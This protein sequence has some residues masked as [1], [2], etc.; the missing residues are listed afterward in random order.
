MV[1]K[2]RWCDDI[3]GSRV[4]LSHDHQDST[5]PG[6]MSPYRELTHS[7]SISPH[8]PPPPTPLSLSFLMYNMCLICS[9]HIK[10]RC[11]CW[12]GWGIAVDHQDSTGPG[13]VPVSPDREQIHSFSL[14]SSLSISFLMYN[15]CLVCGVHIKMRWWCWRVWGTAV[16]WPPRRHR[17]WTCP[18]V[19]L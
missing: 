2:S 17:Y 10:M 8:P 13:P 11:W 6:P 5:G 7:F 1:D 14:S 9:V 18:Y 4:Q 3:G 19:I 15:M 12:R 16:T